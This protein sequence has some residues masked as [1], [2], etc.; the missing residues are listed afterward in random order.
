MGKCIGKKGF[1]MKPKASPRA[2]SVH[3][4]RGEP[5]GSPVD[6]FAPIETSRVGEVTCIEWILRT[7]GARFK[8]SHST[9]FLLC[10]PAGLPSLL[11]VSLRQ[12]SSPTCAGHPSVA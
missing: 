10:G 12:I 6:I 1:S 7:K 4:L 9:A 5:S 3:T 11:Q 2:V 8:T